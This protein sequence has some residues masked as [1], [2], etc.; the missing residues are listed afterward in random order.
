MDMSHS[1]LLAIVTLLKFS[2]SVLSGGLVSY[3]INCLFFIYIFFNTT[4]YI[5]TYTYIY[6][7]HMYVYTYVIVTQ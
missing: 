7:P 3:D 1:K 4:I 5:H 2:D 6:D